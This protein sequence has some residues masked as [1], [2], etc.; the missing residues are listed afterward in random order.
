VHTNLRRVFR[1]VLAGA[2][3]LTAGCSTAVDGTPLADPRATRSSE[4]SGPV[5]LT[6]MTS[7]NDG[8]ADLLTE[9][10]REHSGVTIVEQR[11]DPGAYYPKLQ[12]MLAAGQPPDLAV[13]GDEYRAG[14]FDKPGLFADLAEVGPDDVDPKRWLDWKYE[15]GLGKDDTWFGYGMDSAPIGM[16]YRTDLFAAAGLP[17]DPARVGDLFKSWDSYFAAGDQYTRGTGKPW[18]DSAAEVF[19]AMQNQLDHPYFDQDDKLV[20]ESNTELRTGWDAVTGAVGRGQSAKLE[21]FSP[22]WFSGFR[23]GAFAT[24]PAPYWMLNLIKSQAG[25]ENAGKWA[26][27]GTFPG[28]GANWGGSYLVVPKESPAAEQAAALAAWL[29]APEQQLRLF[30]SVGAFPSQVEALESSELRG[31]T[32]DYFVTKETG[33]IYAELA[34][35]VTV[36]PYRAPRDGRVQTEAMWPA[37]QAVEH[38]TP[39]DAGWQQ[40]VDKAEQ[41]N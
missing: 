16:A 13:V 8:Y 24:A 32:D 30:Q 4:P 37:L 1:V 27:A 26:V 40:A 21:P 39:P 34:D 38:G 22:E 41:V 28:G 12:T 3:V 15:G 11:T 14:L 7:L 25:P 35:K 20:V 18:F 9:Y 36:A 29:T 23:A 33:R 5:T 10:R 31:T 6:F 17:T 19:T 2:V